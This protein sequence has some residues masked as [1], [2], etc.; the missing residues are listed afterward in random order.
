MAAH[1]QNTRDP[2]L[3][4]KFK[5]IADAF[6][7]DLTPDEKRLLGAANLSDAILQDAVE[8]D[9][10]HKGK[11]SGRKV[12]Q[13]LK[14]LIDGINQY[15]AALDVLSNSSSVFVC[16][17]WGSMRVIL[18]LAIEFGEYF[19]KL[20][21]MLER[22][23]RDLASLRRYPKLYPDN[24]RLKHEMVQVYQIIFDFCSKARNV[25]LKGG[26]GDRKYICKFTP[27]GLRT[28]SKLVWKPFKSQFGDLQVQLY[29]AMDVIKQE[30]AL[31][32]NEESSQERRKAQEE[33]QLQ[34]L[35]WEAE[36]THIQEVK[37]EKLRAVAEREAH[38]ARWKETRQAH[39]TL[40]NFVNDQDIAKIET[41]LSPADYNINHN[42]ALK[43][44]H[45]RTGL[46]FLYGDGFQR[47]LKSSNS[48]LWLHAKPGAG[49]T[50]LMASVVDHLK[51]NIQS[52]ER[53]L[54]YFYCDYKDTRKQQPSAIISTILMQL[55]KQNNKVFHKLQAFF[56]EQQKDSRTSSPEFDELRSNFSTFVADA[57]QEVIIVV[58]AIDE[59]TDRRCIMYGLQS[60]IETTSSVKVIVS[61]REESQIVDAFQEWP[62]AGKESTRINQSDVAEDIE[63]FVKAEVMMRIK[64]KKL[65][66]RDESL[67][68]TI[69][70]A[71]VHGADGM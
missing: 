4:L 49:K 38:L 21:S 2:G 69:C 17:I 55:A 62:F 19:D 14:P 50:V 48:F 56:Q 67:K 1:V 51:R 65:K 8:L 71:L 22:I 33:R 35:R 60:I 31:A 24:E 53:G 12:A 3:N 43:L 16:P 41:W 26:E 9:K 36:S 46:W 34:A 40:E 45:Q 68:K 44:R 20:T 70:D 18:H 57:F 30:V 59:C 66:L 64:E 10:R 39:R 27:V 13:K 32:E 6:I 47:W 28:L 54:A 7:K 29:E 63:S 37:E 15:G 11:S 58:D 42:A 25:F 23:G 52:Q 5:S 61:S